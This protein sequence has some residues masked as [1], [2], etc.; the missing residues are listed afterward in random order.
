MNRRWVAFWVVIGLAALG[1]R[2]YRLDAQSLWLDE[3]NSWAM[4]MQ[5]WPVLALD[6]ALPNAAIRSTICY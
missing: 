5:P 2:L 6:L 1:L 3:G 4:A